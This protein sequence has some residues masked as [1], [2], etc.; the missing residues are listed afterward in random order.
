MISVFDLPVITWTL[1][2]AL[3]LTG[4]YFLVQAKRSRE[5]T[6]LVN[7]SLHSFMAVLMASMLWNFGTSTLF[8]Q[9]VI[10][11]GAALWF[12]LQVVARPE[13]K[14]LCAG[15]HSRLR[16]SYHSLTMVG[17]AFMATM[18]MGHATSGQEVFSAGGAAMTHHSMSESAASTA[19]L[20]FSPDPAMVLTGFF[21]VS[22][23]VFLVLL[24]RFRVTS[25]TAQPVGSPLAI[26]VE[27]GVE[28]LGAAV[29]TVMFAAMS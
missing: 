16:C 23:V 1:T 10:L 29:M 18:M 26:R 9:I 25:S 8:V 17:A 20:N 19:L 22:T 2:A 7:N 15:R 12:L 3:F 24:G 4:G 21:G 5:I 13:L 6:D 27:H 28:A 11:I 14:K